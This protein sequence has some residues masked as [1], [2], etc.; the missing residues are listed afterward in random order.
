MT[1]NTFTAFRAMVEKILTYMVGGHNA[2]SAQAG[3]TSIER[4]SV[5]SPDINWVAHSQCTRL[6]I[7]E[8]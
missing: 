3:R 1:Q 7:S 2:G 6:K 8:N 5:Q 4:K